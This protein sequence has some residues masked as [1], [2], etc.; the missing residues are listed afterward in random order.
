MSFKTYTEISD[1]VI[2]DL[3]LEDEQF[4]T[5]TEMMGYCNEAIKSAESEILK[6]CEDYF[7]DVP[8]AISL[9]TGTASYDLPEGIYSDKIRALIYTNGSRI[10]R[11]RRQTRAEKFLDQSLLNQYPNGSNLYYCYDVKNS[12]ADGRKIYFYPTPLETTTDAV[13]IHHIR[14][15]RQVTAGTDIVDIPEFYTYIEQY[16]KV[17]CYEK[18]GHPNFAAANKKLQDYL[19]QMVSSLGNRFPDNETEI[20]MDMSFYEDFS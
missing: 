2:L 1:K 10:Y 6:I 4:I 20:E 13:L 19:V 18:E 7:L 15:A 11:I 8:T 14:T 16:M 5:A 9:V 3:D 12:L 17:R